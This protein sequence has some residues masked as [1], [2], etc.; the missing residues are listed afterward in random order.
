VAYNLELGFRS[1]S[2]NPHLPSITPLEYIPDHL[3]SIHANRSNA[4]RVGMGPLNALVKL[5]RGEALAW[6]DGDNLRITYVSTSKSQPGK[7]DVHARSING[8][9]VWRDADGATAPYLMGLA[10]AVVLNRYPEV[11]NAYDALV[12]HARSQLGLTL[13]NQDAGAWSAL[14]QNPTT[15]EHIIRLTDALYY[16]ILRDH[17][18]GTLTSDGSVTI[19]EVQGRM[20]SSS[21]LRMNGAS[22]TQ[23]AAPQPQPT[24]APTTIDLSPLARLMRLG[25]HGG[26]ALLSGPT[27]TFK[28]ETA[29]RFAVTS[30]AK[31]VSLKGAAGLEDRDFWGAIIPTPAGPEWRD[32]PLT[33][34]F[35]NAQSAKTVLIIDELLRFEPL[36]ANVLVG[37]LDVVTPTELTAMGFTPLEE[38]PHYCVTLPSGEV[39]PAPKRNL[40]IVGTTNLGDDYTQFTD[41]DSALLGRFELQI[42]MNEADESVLVSIYG[43]IINKP[44]L[45]KALLEFEGWTRNNTGVHGGLLKRATNPRVT[46]NLLRETA[47]LHEEGMPLRDALTSALTVTLMPY[48]SPR[49]TSGALAEDACS[50]LSDEFRKVARAA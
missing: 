9:R 36:Y 37:A 14:D 42:D 40:T 29:K 25:K 47:R 19:P 11:V 24:P 34:A 10:E 44:K 41:L 31:L 50:V 39:I 22:T 38:G 43:S 3:R 35:R 46:I 30:G 2:P 5:L 15:R 7:R 12:A 28:T 23:Q 18:G 20:L 48:C 16:A 27:G 32:G 21:D 26:T 8:A 6:R 17:E 45:I 13:P 49:D 4:S 33:R 1:K